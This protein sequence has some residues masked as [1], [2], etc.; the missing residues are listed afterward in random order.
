MNDLILKFK[1]N[2]RNDYNQIF[3]DTS[4]DDIKELSQYKIILHPSFN[5]DIIPKGTPP[6]QLFKQQYLKINKGHSKDYKQWLVLDYSV[7]PI[8]I[9]FQSNQKADC[10]NWIDEWEI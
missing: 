8:G 1:K 10:E 5:A 9:V 7:K 4:I 6:S 3:H 2:R